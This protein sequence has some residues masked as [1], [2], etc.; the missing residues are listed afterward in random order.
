M[1]LLVM[2][3]RAHRARCATNIAHHCGGSAEISRVCRAVPKVRP[4]VVG[5]SRGVARIAGV[6]WGRLMVWVAADWWLLVL[7]HRGV[8]AHC[9]VHPPKRTCG[10][11]G[12]LVRPGLVGVVVVR[13]DVGG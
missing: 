8:L 12:L 9:G 10:R 4:M 3:G 11:R 1:W 7:P 5:W 6:V 13:H 2:M